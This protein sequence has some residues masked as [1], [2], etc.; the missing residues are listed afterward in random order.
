MGSSKFVVSK[1]TTLHNFTVS[2]WGGT[3][4]ASGGYCVASSAEDLQQQNERNVRFFT[5]LNIKKKTSFFAIQGPQHSNFDISEMQIL[6]FFNRYQ[7]RCFS[8]NVIKKIQYE[9]GI[10]KNCAYFWCIWIFKKKTSCN[11]RAKAFQLWNVNTCF[12]V[13]F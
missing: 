3:C 12:F 10:S 5:D 8:Y 11:L 2:R 9:K 13:F 7:L 4:A 6:V 1:D